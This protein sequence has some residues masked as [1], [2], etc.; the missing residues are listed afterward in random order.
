MRKLLVLLS[1][2]LLFFFCSACLEKAADIGPPLSETP[3]S[4]QQISSSATLPAPQ[5]S[6]STVIPDPTEIILSLTPT[7]A[8]EVTNEPEITEIPQ[9]TTE[10]N[11]DAL[12][13]EHYIYNISGHKQYFPLGCE[14]S[15]AIDWVTYFGYEINEFEFQT[16]LPLS[17]NPDFGFV[18]SVKSPWGQT[19]PYGYG[20][21]AY[22][23]ADL[24]NEYGVNAV[25]VKDYTI[26]KIKE[27][28]AQDRP[29]IAWVI[30]NCV[31][32]IP[33]EYTDSQGNTTIVA[34]YEHVVV[35]TGYSA[36]RIRYMNNGNFY[37][38]PVEVF[39]NSWS[40]LQ[41]MVIYL[42]PEE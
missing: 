6:V 31:G 21:H 17:D 3:V 40:V 29:V 24:L 14:T 13:E 35:V 2:V 19:P 23:V 5:V 33:A 11:S 26:E 32:G 36:D 9:Q 15:A 34:A 12:P 20:V 22:P 10:S 42:K 38:V 41:N 39:E 37:E 27:E 4:T 1:I 25:G 16:R 7:S 8:A 28:I 30:G 18:G